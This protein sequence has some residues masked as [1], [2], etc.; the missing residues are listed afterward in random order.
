MIGMKGAG[1]ARIW[2]A[3]LLPERCGDY[4]RFAEDVSLPMFKSHD[5]FLGVAMMHNQ[6]AACVIT[7]WSGMDAVRSL[8][9]SARYRA[10]V[11]AIKATGV[12]GT[13]GETVVMETHLSD[14]T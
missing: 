13:F 1:I 8:E 7:Y 4:D 14:F 10:T 12:I 2:T 5:G 9:A 3:T 6:K 11:E